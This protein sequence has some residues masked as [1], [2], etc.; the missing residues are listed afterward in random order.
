MLGITYKRRYG[1]ATTFALVSISRLSL[2]EGSFS[3]GTKREQGTK[4]AL[5]LL[6]IAYPLISLCGQFLTEVHYR[7]TIFHFFEIYAGSLSAGNEHGF[8]SP[9]SLSIPSSEAHQGA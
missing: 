3:T 5:V 9:G 8:M 6:L 2:G 1:N 7:C 4:V